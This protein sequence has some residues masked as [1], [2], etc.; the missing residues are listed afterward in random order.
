MSVKF[1]SGRR[2]QLTDT[3]FESTSILSGS[4]GEN[5]L[6]VIFVCCIRLGA[7]GT[8]QAV[9]MFPFHMLL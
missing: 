9:D 2:D 3:A 5:M 4:T 6:L 7:N 1:S 8:A